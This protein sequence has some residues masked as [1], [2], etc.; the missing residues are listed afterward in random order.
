MFKFFKGE[1]KVA[2][3]V[4]KGGAGIVLGFISTLLI[5]V[6]V[7][8]PASAPSKPDFPRLK[9]MRPTSESANFERAAVLSRPDVRAE[10]FF[11]FDPAA[12]LSFHFSF[13]STQTQTE[14]K[15]VGDLPGETKIEPDPI[16]AG[17]LCTFSASHVEVGTYKLAIDL[18]GAGEAQR[19]LIHVL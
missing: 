17:A 3:Q 2:N 11:K 7:A 16:T 4:L 10:L 15:F 1:I 9:I 19:F 14:A 6:V 18:E 8:S 13:I 5:L 12:P